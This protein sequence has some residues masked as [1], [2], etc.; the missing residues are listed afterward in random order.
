MK[1]A[2]SGQNLDPNDPDYS[3]PLDSCV[4]GGGPTPQ[5]AAMISKSVAKSPVQTGGKIPV[6]YNGP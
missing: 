5:E 3:L 6:G 1:T 4:G 2:I